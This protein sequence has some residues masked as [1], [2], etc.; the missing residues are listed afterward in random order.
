[1]ATLGQMEGLVL[2]ID[3]CRRDNQRLEDD[4]IALQ[5]SSQKLQ[6]ELMVV[7]QEKEEVT[8]A[9]QERKG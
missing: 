7:R 4:K 5:L 3:D 6:G 2:Q 9:W 8:R 1:M